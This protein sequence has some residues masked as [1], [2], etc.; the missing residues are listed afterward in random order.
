MPI[1]LDNLIQKLN[2]FEPIFDVLIITFTLIVYVPCIGGL[3]KSMTCQIMLKSVPGYG[4][5]THVAMI[6]V[7]AQVLIIFH[8]SFLIFMKY[9]VIQ[10]A[11]KCQHI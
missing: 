6:T 1:I 11:S 8:Y 9:D 7:M 2:Y 5:I 4:V 10:D 3:N